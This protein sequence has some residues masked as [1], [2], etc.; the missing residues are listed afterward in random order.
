MNC[1]KCGRQGQALLSWLRGRL[2]WL[3]RRLG[4]ASPI[5]GAI[6]RCPQCGKV[7]AEDASGS[8]E[9]K[10]RQAPEP[11]EDGEAKVPRRKPTLRP[12]MVGGDTDIAFDRTGE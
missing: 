12:E 6:W 11:E 8:F 5:T 3:R 1:P 2:G 10:L 4:L 7:W 9:V